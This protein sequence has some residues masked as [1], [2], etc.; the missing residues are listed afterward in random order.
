M[1]QRAG[2]LA[3]ERGRRAHRAVSRAGQR[4]RP[5]QR[6]PSRPRSRTPSHATRHQPG[7]CSHSTAAHG[8]QEPIGALS[9][10]RNGWRGPGRAGVLTALYGSSYG[11]RSI[12]LLERRSTPNGTAAIRITA[13]DVPEVVPLTV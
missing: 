9:D 5:L 7:D 8:S 3:S 1:V 13:K 10:G 4:G 11:T 12:V 6:P 2:G